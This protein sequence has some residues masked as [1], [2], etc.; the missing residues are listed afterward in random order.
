MENNFESVETTEVADPSTEI[1]SAESPE[2]ADPET[3]EQA[4]TEEV[5]AQETTTEEPLR[6]ESDRAFAEQRRHIQELERQNSLLVGAL[7]RYFE[8]EDAEDLSVQALAHADQRDPEAVRAELARDLELEELRRER[9]ELRTAQLDME[10]ENL[11]R[12]SL[13]EIQAIDPSVKSLDELGETFVNFIGAGLSAKE[14]YYATQVR[15][16]K[17]KVYAPSPI[18]KMSDTRV[19]RDHYT[20]EELDNLSDEEMD[21]NWD[22]VMRS[23]SML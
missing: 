20:S 14:A 1:E 9:D 5:E 16:G 12:R 23:M 22:K 19:E 13:N 21:A 11:M 10:V 8:G 15:D 18:G 2:V 7:G 4:E 17:E 6:T 3:T